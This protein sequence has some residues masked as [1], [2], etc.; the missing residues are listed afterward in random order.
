MEVVID[1]SAIIA[2]I[3]DEPEKEQLVR[4]TYGAS[5]LAPASLPW[6]IGN[7]FSAMFRR[8][9]LTAEDAVNAMH[10]WRTIP[11]RIVD[12]DIVQAVQ[13]A[14]Q[15]GIYAYDAYFIQ[16]AALYKTPL[17]TLDRHLRESAVM[18]GV[19]ILEVV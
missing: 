10:V 7:A 5:L 1:T 15:L 6:E 16:T 2:V 8:Q 11:L 18:A 12:V 14:G 3:L 9:R 4:M 13:M 19:Q 17:L